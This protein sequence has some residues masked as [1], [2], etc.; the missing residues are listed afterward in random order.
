MWDNRAI[1]YRGARYQLGR[2]RRRYA[3]WLAGAPPSRPVEEWPET[4][5]GWAA[6]WARF[7]AVEQPGT[8]T[9]LP[10]PAE[11]PAL[12]PAAL[13]LFA[14]G[15]VAGIAGL[16]PAYLSGQSLAT[17]PDQLA[18]HLIYLATWAA[19]ALL[20]LAGGARR[21]AGL[22]LGLGT[23]AVTFGFFLA[24]VGQVIAGGTHLLGAGLVLSVLGWLGCT[25]G[26]V[27]IFRPGRAELP[28]RVA[29]VRGLDSRVAGLLAVTGLAA[30]GAAITF[31]PSWDR[32]TLTTAAGLTRSIT[33]GNAFANPAP[34]IAGDVA[35]MVALVA[36]AVI[37]A[38]WRP[39]RLGAALLAGALLPMVANAVS[40]LIQIGQP[41]SPANFGI[42]PAAAAQAGVT[43]S[44]GLTPV[45]WVYCL[46]LA[47][48]ALTIAGML[49]PPR[50]R[51]QPGWY[52]ARPGSGPAW[53]PAAPAAGWAPPVAGPP[54]PGTPVPG[55]GTPAPGTPPPGP[56]APGSPAPGPAGP[57]E[58]APVRASGPA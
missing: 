49:L 45:F 54:A 42:P 44:A 17:H 8:I 34:V 4:P 56:A 12:V 31:A 32:Y 20:I 3:I 41:L 55:P 10:P 58:D 18:P 22:L 47:A 40:A 52:P 36:V 23:S 28:R 16:F 51:R 19:S 38:L 2:A 48:L 9:Q 30:L 25:A 13:A 46:F 27:L 53:A 5:E 6:A 7:T 33:A 24:D 37:A 43:V 57:A 15:L 29:A 26:A 1:W 39:A 50:P 35:V 11:P 21:R 14:A